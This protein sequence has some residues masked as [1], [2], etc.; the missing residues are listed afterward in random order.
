MPQ[1]ILWVFD[2]ISS[3]PQIIIQTDILLLKPEEFCNPSR[4]LET[5]PARIFVFRFHM[6]GAD[7]LSIEDTFL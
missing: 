4:L 3:Q 1:N 2:V 6:C 7:L 5:K